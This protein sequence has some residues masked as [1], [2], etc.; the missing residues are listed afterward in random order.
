MRTVPDV[1]GHIGSATFSSSDFEIIGGGFFAAIGTSA[2]APDFAALLAIK[3][4]VQHSRL[5]LE[6]P[7]IYTLA[8]H[9]DQ[10]GYWYFHQS[11]PGS[12]GFYTYTRAHQGYNYI[13]GVGSPHGANFALLPFSPLAGDPQTPTNP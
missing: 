2:S 12:D 1:G 7:D 9:N 4:S 8:A 5:G 6:N 13:Y 3:A 11:N 10:L